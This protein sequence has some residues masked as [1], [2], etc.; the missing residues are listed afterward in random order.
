MLTSGGARAPS[1]SP[2]PDAGKRV[3]PGRW[4]NDPAAGFRLRLATRR[5]S[6]AARARWNR[7][8]EGAA[9][10]PLLSALDPH[11]RGAA[12]CFEDRAMVEMA[13]TKG[14]PVAT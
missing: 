9:A 11:Q 7:R 10:D 13:S 5:L 3:R 2:G 14:T 6:R 4:L 1:T 12:A 8:A